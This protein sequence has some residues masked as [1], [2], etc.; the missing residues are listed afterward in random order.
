V[1]RRA[2][3]FD[4]AYAQANALATQDLDE[5]SARLLAFQRERID[6]RDAGRHLISSAVR[7]PARTPHVTHGKPVSTSFWRRLTG[8]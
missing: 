1:L 8:R 7:P 6:A 4:A 2:E 3:A 5:T